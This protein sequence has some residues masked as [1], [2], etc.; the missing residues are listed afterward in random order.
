MRLRELLTFIV[1]ILL[2]LFLLGLGIGLKICDDRYA[3]VLIVLGFFMNALAHFF[4][5]K[6]FWVHLKSLKR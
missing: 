3:V 2:S 4:L 1:S 5:W 6:K